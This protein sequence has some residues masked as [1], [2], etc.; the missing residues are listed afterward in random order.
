[1]T[2]ALSRHGDKSNRVAP[3]REFFSHVADFHRFHAA[4]GAAGK[5]QDIMEMG[6]EFFTRG[7]A[8][9]LAELRGAPEMSPARRT[10]LAHAFAG[11]LFSLLS[12]WLHCDKAL[13]AAQMDDLFHQMVWASTGLKTVPGSQV[14]RRIE[15]RPLKGYL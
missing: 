9:R 11:A 7:I 6:Q 5:I 10:I 14:G 13:P 8:Q 15:M 3:V 12:W 2:T 1:M 4:M